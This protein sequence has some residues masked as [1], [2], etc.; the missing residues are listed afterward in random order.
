[1]FLRCNNGVNCFATVKYVEKLLGQPKTGSIALPENPATP[2][3]L[4]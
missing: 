4:Q 1:M 2:N 3:L